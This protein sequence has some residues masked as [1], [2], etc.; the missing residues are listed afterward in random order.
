MTVG[1]IRRGKHHVMTEI[2]WKA[3]AVSR[4]YQVSTGITRS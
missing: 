3:E 2:D 1:L 4:E